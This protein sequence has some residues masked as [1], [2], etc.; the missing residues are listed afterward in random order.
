VTAIDAC[1]ISRLSSVKLHPGKYIMTDYRE[2][3]WSVT[4]WAAFWCSLMAFL[5]YIIS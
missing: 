4:L 1:Q 3:Y 5:V 2:N